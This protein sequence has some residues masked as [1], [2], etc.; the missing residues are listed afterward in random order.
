MR[1]GLRVLRTIIAER[2]SSPKSGVEVEPPGY[3]ELEGPS[4]AT[5]SLLAD[6]LDSG[7]RRAVPRLGL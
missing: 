1:D 3:R 6:L 2:L 5:G 4:R 7:D